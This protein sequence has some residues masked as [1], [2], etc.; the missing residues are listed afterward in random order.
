MVSDQLSLA[1][2]IHR[3]SNQLLETLMPKYGP[4][5]NSGLILG[6]LHQALSQALHVH[7]FV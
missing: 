2:F 4:S 5:T 3:R 1:Y 6:T 7:V